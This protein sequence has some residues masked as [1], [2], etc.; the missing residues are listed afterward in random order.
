MKRVVVFGLLLCS[1][2]VLPAFQAAV[3][4]EHLISGWASAGPPSEF[5]EGN[6]FD[7]IDGGAEIFLEFGFDRL[8]VQDYRKGHSEIVLELYQMESSESALGI[9][10]MKCGIET[11]IEGV[12]ARNS[13]DRTQF[14]ILKGRAFI[15]INNPEGSESSLPVMVDL[16]RAVLKFIPQGEPV[17]LL[18]ELPLEGR[19]PGS[20]RLIRGPYALESIFTF[21]EGDVFELQGKIFAVAADYRDQDGEPSTRLIISYPNELRAAAAFRNLL[22]NLDPY[23][24]VIEKRD[25]GVV[26]E[27]YRQKIGTVERNGSRLEIRVNLIAR[28]SEPSSFWPQLLRKPAAVSGGT[29]LI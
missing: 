23:L 11:P 22:D 16:A 4:P 12:P 24:K 21:G 14:T 26:F 17:T 15:Q 25:R 8:L 13:G 1:V 3:L 2:Q 10:L 9:Y 5:K 7:Y 20:E 6:L 19:I 29:G 18:D 27:D 28:P